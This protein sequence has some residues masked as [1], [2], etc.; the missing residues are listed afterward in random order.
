MYNNG[1]CCFTKSYSE[2]WCLKREINIYS[3]F[4]KELNYRI[5]KWPNCEEAAP[6]YSKMPTKTCRRNRRISKSTFETPNETI[7]SSQDHS[8]MLKQ[9]D[10]GW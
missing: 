9:K 2:N 10:E 6:I 1:G 3:A 7:Y 4:Q 8:W 5:T